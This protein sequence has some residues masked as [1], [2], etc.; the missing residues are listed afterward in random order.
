MRV[1]G[2]PMILTERDGFRLERFLSFLLRL[3]GGLDDL[4][5][6]GSDVGIEI[7]N[8]DNSNETCSKTNAW[9]IIGIIKAIMIRG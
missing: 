5:F 7:Q 4:G 8:S 1:R 2:E 9:M 6:K 3:D